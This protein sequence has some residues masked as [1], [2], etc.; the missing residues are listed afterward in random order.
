MQQVSFIEMV[1]VRQC[2]LDEQGLTSM[3]RAVRANCTLR[4]LHLEGN[5]LTGKGVF[6]LSELSYNTV[7]IFYFCFY[8][9]TVAAMKFNEYLKE[10]YLGGNRIIPEDCQ[11]IGNILRTN[12]TLTHLD[13]RDNSIQ[14]IYYC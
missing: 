11:N 5:N 2:A 10:L 13:L 7:Y 14:V 6:I 4:I 1:D 3:L 9:F 12:H 8:F